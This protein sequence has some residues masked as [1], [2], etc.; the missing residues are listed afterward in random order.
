MDLGA[1]EWVKLELDV[2]AFDPS[3]FA[4]DARRVEDSGVRVTTLFELGD[5]PEHRRK[6]F[7]LNAECS[8]DIPS[9]GEFHTWEEY[10][11]LRLAAPSFLSR[12]VTLALDGER[13]V[14]MSALSHRA[15]YG[16]AFH[17]MT[18]TIRSHRGRGIATA[19]KITVVEFARQ[20][21]VG[22]IRTVHHP[23]NVR[24]IRLNRR[25]GYVDADWDYPTR[26]PQPTNT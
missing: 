21:G 1:V 12:G 24:M 3:C 16:Y 7:E 23:G 19:M 26:R 14:G 25:I 18:G 9:R 11:E 17:D 13:W 22:T 6:L 10:Q 4:A 2:S 20:L 5:T 8:A 15:G